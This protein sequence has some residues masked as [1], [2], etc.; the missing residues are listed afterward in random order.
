M[1][2]RLCKLQAPLQ[3]LKS[4]KPQSDLPADF[5][6]SHGKA[7]G[8]LPGDGDSGGSHYWERVLLQDHCS[9]SVPFWSPLL[10]PVRAEE[11]VPSTRGQLQPKTLWATQTVTE[12]LT[13][14]TR[15]SQWRRGQCTQ[16]GQ[17]HPNRRTRAAPQGAL[18]EQAGLVTV[19]EQ[20]AGPHRASL[21]PV[22]FSNTANC[23]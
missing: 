20:A 14:T 1:C 17:P 18:L 22:Y 3:R 11:S 10:E 8:A 16:S 7:V 5:G 23:H 9:W 13:P 12:G 4:E 19:A 2:I 15:G 6:E 21:V